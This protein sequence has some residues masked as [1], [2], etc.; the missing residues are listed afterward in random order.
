MII[1]AAREETKG[2]QVCPA[3]RPCEARVD[4]LKHDYGA[5]SVFWL[6]QK[7]TE[8]FAQ[9]MRSMATRSSS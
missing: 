3:G 5:I 9:G 4:P 2:L 8:S 7:R 1:A 6:G